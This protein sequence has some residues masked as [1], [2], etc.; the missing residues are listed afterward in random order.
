VLITFSYIFQWVDS[1]EDAAYVS[2][3]SLA[4]TSGQEEGPVERFDSFEA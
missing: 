1:G 4:K 3:I 2:G